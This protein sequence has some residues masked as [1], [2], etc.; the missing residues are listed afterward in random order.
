MAYQKRYEL[1]TNWKL[2]AENFR[3]CYHCGPAHPEY[4]NA[5]VGANLTRICLKK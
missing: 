2:I 5:V 3:E 1:R 4:C